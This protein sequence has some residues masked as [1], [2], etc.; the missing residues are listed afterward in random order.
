[1]EQLVCIMEKFVINTSLI[2]NI[3][4]SFA[5][6]AALLAFFLIWKVFIYFKLF[7]AVAEQSEEKQQ[8]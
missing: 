1:M 7:T 4:D 8:M 5:T 6:G 2:N 3:V